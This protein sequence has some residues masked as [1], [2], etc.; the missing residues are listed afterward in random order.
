MTHQFKKNYARIKKKIIIISGHSGAGKS[1]IVRNIINDKKFSSYFCLS[2]S[3][4]TRKI[5]RNEVDGIDYFFVSE[6]EFKKKKKK[7]FFIEYNIYNGNY[8]G[9]PRNFLEKD[10]QNYKIPL[11][12]IDVNGREKISEEIG[13]EY[14]VSIFIT[15]Q[16]SS[17]KSRIKERDVSQLKKKMTSEEKSSIRNRLYKHYDYESTTIWKSNY[18]LINEKLS[19]TLERIKL[20]VKKNFSHFL[21]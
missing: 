17:L 5:R 12:E 4:T 3:F 10:I 1:T 18:I 13:K 19:K 6:S 21:S 15:A 2:T 14:V 20:I 16:L 8:Y 11:L 7:N 9:T